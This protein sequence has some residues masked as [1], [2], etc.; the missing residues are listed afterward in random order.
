GD[1]PE[2]RIPVTVLDCTPEVRHG[3]CG[4]RW[5]CHDALPWIV[6]R[7][8]GFE[9]KGRLVAERRM[10][11]LLVVD[12]RDEAVDAATGVV[13]VEESL[14]VDLFGLERLHETFG[15][16]VVEG[17]ARPAHAEGDVTIG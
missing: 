11:A 4:D 9:L 8:C 14:A 5:G 2:L 12:L 15:F 10:E 1:I 7:E 16:G 6:L 13:E 17:I 3:N